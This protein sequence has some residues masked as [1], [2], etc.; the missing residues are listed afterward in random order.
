MACIDELTRLDQEVDEA[1]RRALRNLAEHL[2]EAV[3]DLPSQSQLARSFARHAANF[4][5]WGVLSNRGHGATMGKS[6]LESLKR[7]IWQA[8]SE[9]VLADLADVILAV[10]EQLYPGAWRSALER[11]ASAIGGH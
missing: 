9:D 2:R 10:C 5:K 3:R 7:E 11:V 6:E 4:E 8:N 1:E